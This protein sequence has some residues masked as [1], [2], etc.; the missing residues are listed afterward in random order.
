LSAEE[1]TAAAQACGAF[2]RAEKSWELLR[3]NV[4]TLAEPSKAVIW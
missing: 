3:Y 2:F 4:I 1:I